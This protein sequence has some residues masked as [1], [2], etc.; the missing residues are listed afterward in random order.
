MTMNQRQ[1][2]SLGL[3]LV[4][5]LLPLIAMRFT[6]QVLWTASDFILA[7]ILLFGTAFI[8]ELIIKFIHMPK[9]RFAFILS[10]L[11]ILI[12]VWI[13]LAVDWVSL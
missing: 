8:I 7:A 3:I 6:F 4:I 5:L 2:I 10:S 12:L 1:K 11:L 13:Q 9:M